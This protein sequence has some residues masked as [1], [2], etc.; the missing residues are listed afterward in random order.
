MNGCQSISS[1][2]QGFLIDTTGFLTFLQSMTTGR[3]RRFWRTHLYIAAIAVLL[4]AAAQGQPAP[5]RELLNSERIAAAF[6]SY[7]VE[8]L[9]QDEQVRVSNLYSGT[10]DNPTCRTLAVVRY[11]APMDPAVGAQHAAIVAGG[12]LGATFAAQGWEVRK[13]HLSYTERP[14]TAKLA[15]LMRIGAG[16][17]LAEH[18]YVLDV[19][20]GG[21]AIEYAALVEIHHPDYLDVG[22]LE[23]IYGAVGEG[24]RE[25]V[26]QMRATATD[27]TR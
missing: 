24:R 4:Q 1:I 18:V 10:A 27:R 6:G 3:M 25:L 7:G 22:G 2:W 16:T 11:T 15:A 26:A 17:P 5:A 9:G 13:T 20:K 8:V 12:S 19:V 21:R 14:A 23:R